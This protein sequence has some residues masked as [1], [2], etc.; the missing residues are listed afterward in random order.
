MPPALLSRSITIRMQPKHAGEQVESYIAPDAG[1]RAAELR[2]LCRAWAERHS[3]KLRDRRPDLVGLTN[4]RAEVWWPLLVLGEYVGGEWQERA[5]TAT[6]VLGAGGDETDR[7][8]EQVQLLMDIDAAF[9]KNKT[10]FTT[11][12]LGKLN[13]STRAP[14]ERGVGVHRGVHRLLPQPGGFE[15]VGAMAGL[16]ESSEVRQ[17]GSGSEPVAVTPRGGRA[18]RRGR[19]RRRRCAGGRTRPSRREVPMSLTLVTE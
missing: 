10:I 15:G 9:G 8:A 18:R 13:A 4:R 12:L 11:E 1:P 6:Q 17:T 7:P 14:G 2:D 19:S 5:Q 3:D 16:R